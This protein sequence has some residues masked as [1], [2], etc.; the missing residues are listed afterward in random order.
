MSQAVAIEMC[1]LGRR[2]VVA[3]SLSLLALASGCGGGGTG[4]PSG[5]LPSP[6][7]VTLTV[8]STAGGTVASVPSGIS[9]GPSCSNDYPPGTSVTLTA[10]PAVGYALEE[11][12]GACGGT[13]A[14][15]TLLLD[16]SA[17]VSASF[18]LVSKAGAPVVSYSDAL[19]GPVS[20]GEGN[21]GGYLSIFGSNFGA[22]S[23]LGTATKV[24]IGGVEVANYR[25]LGPAKVGSKLGLQ[26]LTVQVGGLGNPTLGRP[27]PIKVVVNGTASN[28]DNTFTPSAGRILFVSLSGNDSTAVA[29]DIGKPWR[30]LQNQGAMTGAYFASRA[31]DQIVIRGGDWS[32]TNGWDD[33][34]MRAASD[35]S[36]RNGT[37][38]AWIH[39][40]A[41]PGPIN[42]NA[43]ED[44]HYTTPARKRGGIAGPWSAITGTSGEY[45]SVSN[46]R[47]E[48][49]GQATSDAAPINL[50]YTGGHWRVVN[51]EL[52]PWPVSGVADAKAG[53]V[54]G[55][56][57]DV[58][59]LG[60]HIHH[61]GGTSA[62]ENH[63]IYAD[64]ATTNWQVA[65]NWIHDVTGGSLVQFNDSLGQA[66]T[67][68]LP[69]GGIWQGFVGMRVHNNW[70]ENAA[71][72]GLNIA[73]AGS[74]D[75]QVELRAWNNVIVGTRLPAVRMNSTASTMDI[76]I[77][78]N[79]IYNAMVSDSGTGNGYFRNEDQGR[80]AIRVYDNVLALGPNTTADTQW[81]YDYS[82]DSGGWLFSNNLYWD[83]GRNV[84]PIASDGAA[85]AADPQ[86][87]SAASGNFALSSG[88]PALG[89]A[90]QAIPFAVTD[91]FTGKPLRPVGGVN[92]IGAFE[93]GP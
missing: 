73:D 80:G 13:A 47:M 30:Y 83:S 74:V 1:L 6:S 22:S 52:G 89:K 62:L 23:G 37:A 76:T 31:G 32:D 45:F 87:V 17:S 72:Y 91:D 16:Q 38:A 21:Q 49:S 51:N 9:C 65:Y 7:G 40:T 69:H 67:Y 27:L 35:S 59:I 36:A 42:G 70:L 77:A 79:T 24:Y 64:T 50:Q 44:V 3:A 58:K 68:E 63:G 41:Y 90:L 81:F 43:I 48:V 8:T 18:A 4:T 29:N 12:S 56:G 84:P 75:G 54:A 11:W 71:K 66:G 26:Q 88:S 57:D 10:V 60:N 15:C 86:F 20:G 55:Y 28:V 85:V 2:H 61:I 14:T 92:A 39:I 19:T 53:G 82:G 25:Y 46:L 34:W 33:T 93:A 78:Y 5:L